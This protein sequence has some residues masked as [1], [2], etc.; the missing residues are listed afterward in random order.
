[1]QSCEFTL[2]YEAVALVYLTICLVFLKDLNAACGF[3]IKYY[4]Q[5]FLKAVLWPTLLF[6]FIGYLKFKNVSYAQMRDFLFFVDTYRYVSFG[7]WTLYNIYKIVTLQME[8]CRAQQTN[9]I[10][11]NYE[12]LIV[13]GVF[14]AVMLVGFLFIALM[15][16]PYIAYSL[17]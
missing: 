16:F 7:S 8:Q 13:F 1:M 3:N 5:I 6:R 14:P 9:L 2:A 4:T 12:L 17:Y 11:L 10:E 15:C